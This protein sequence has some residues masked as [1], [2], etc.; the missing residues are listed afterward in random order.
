MK[1]AFFVAALLALPLACDKKVDMGGAC[2]NAAKCK[3]GL[4]CL[5]G[6]CDVCGGPAAKGEWAQLQCAKFGLCVARDGRCV[7]ASDADCKASG[8]CR[9]L[10]RC[11]VKAGECTVGADEHCKQSDRCKTFGHCIARNGACASS[12]PP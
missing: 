4:A 2:G 11:V 9:L 7:A 5:E 6:K 3:E 12:A 8:A 10:G 1:T